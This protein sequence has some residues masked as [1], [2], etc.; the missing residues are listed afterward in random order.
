MRPRKVLFIRDLVVEEVHIAD[1]HEYAYYGRTT[2]PVLFGH[3]AV[4]V[5]EVVCDKKIV[6]FNQICQEGKPD[7]FIAYSEEV[8]EL[9]GQ[10]I[11]AIKAQADYAQKQATNAVARY[12]RNLRYLNDLKSSFWRRLNFLFGSYGE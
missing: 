7:L 2:Q 1:V 8:E 10:P 11:R 9:L 4:A 6:P 12:H 5:S 3:D